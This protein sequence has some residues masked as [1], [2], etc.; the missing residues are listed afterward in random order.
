MTSGRRILLFAVGMI[1]AL[2]GSA[3]TTYLRGRHCLDAGGSWELAKRQCIMP[4]GGSPAG[5]TFTESIAGIGTMI[6]L[7][8]V[9]Y[10]IALIIH[11]RRSH[12][13]ARTDGTENTGRG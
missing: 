1:A 11:R 9:L 7:A 5:T 3:M 13:G 6:V 2:G 10:R 8:V 12:V 4:T